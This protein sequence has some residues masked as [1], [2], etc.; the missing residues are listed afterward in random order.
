[1]AAHRRACRHRSGAARTP[2]PPAEKATAQAPTRGPGTVAHTKTPRPGPESEVRDRARAQSM[3]GWTIR[4][5]PFRG[6]GLGADRHDDVARDAGFGL[7]AQ[8]ASRLRFGVVPVNKLSD[9]GLQ[10]AR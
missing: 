7:A 10:S 8:S 9:A 6:G 5:I 2:S 4:E 1:V 3:S